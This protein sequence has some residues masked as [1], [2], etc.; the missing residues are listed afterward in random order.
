MSKLLT[1]EQ[2][3]RC[4]KYGKDR[5]GDNLAVYSDHVFCFS[6]GYT[7]QIQSNVSLKNYKSG[8]NAQSYP[9]RTGQKTCPQLPV[10]FVLCLPDVG[11]QWI[12]QYEITDKE[13]AQHRIGWSE[14]GFTIRGPGN[15]PIQYKPC[16]VFP[17]YD[18]YGNLLMWQAR[19]FGSEK[20]IKSKYVTRGKTNDI[21][22]IVGMDSDPSGTITIVEDIISAIKCSRF[23]NSLPMWGSNVS[24]SNI[25]RISKRYSNVN[26][27]LD[28]D[29]TKEAH[30][31]KAQIS[32]FFENVRVISTIKDPKEIQEIEMRILLS[33]K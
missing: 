4:R 6:C 26:I 33:G 20:D 11:Y 17:I 18:I 14:N 23:T 12:K 16:M 19:Y 21:L 31:L 10:D 29:K 8:N 15:N 28:Y 2:C 1:H 27:W 24:S 30:K 3:P 13:I 7:K 25:H 32:P 5:S 22:H 9:E